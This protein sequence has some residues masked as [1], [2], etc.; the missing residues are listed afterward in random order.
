LIGFDARTD[1]AHIEAVRRGSARPA[2][3]RQISWLAP[4]FLFSEQF[5]ERTK[6]AIRRF[7]DDLPFEL[8][9]QRGNSDLVVHLTEQ[10]AEWGELAEQE[11]YQARPHEGD[12]STVE[13]VHVSPSAAK[14]ENVVKAEKATTSLQEGNLWV[15]ASKIF[16]HEKIEDEASVKT[17]LA[18]ARKLDT[19]NL[20]AASDDEDNLGMR[21]GA[22]AG[23]AAVVLRFR[24]GRS[25]DELAWARDAVQ[26]ATIAPEVRGNFWMPESAIP[27][28]HS[29]YAARGLA[30]DIRCGTA[31]P[32]APGILLALAAHPLE[33]VSLAAVKAALSLWDIDA[34][35][36]WAALSIALTLCHVE[37]DGKRHHHNDP[38]HSETQIRKLLRSVLKDYERGKKWMDLPSPPPAWVKVE[39][40]REKRREPTYV[41]DDDDYYDSSTDG[42]TQ[43]R[44]FWRSKYA[45]KVIDNVPFEIALASPPASALLD[46]IDRSL[47]WT[48]DKIEPPW[49]KGSHRR[50]RRA[51]EH[52]EW[53]HGFG[54]V[55]GRLAGILPVDRA[56][57]L[58]VEPIL[59]LDG[60]P[61]WSLLSPFTSALVCRYVYDAANVPNG[62]IEI[63]SICLDKLLA[64]PELKKRSDRGGELHGFDLPSLAQTL[65]FVSVEKADLAAR[66]VNGDWSQIEMILPLV[67]R[68]VR[69]AG[70]SGTVMG[71]F[72]TLCERSRSH[73]PSEAFADQVLSILQSRDASELRGWHGTFLPARIASLV[74]HFAVRDTPMPVALG[75][76]LLR[77]LDVLVDMG[78]RRSAA[79]QLSESFREVRLA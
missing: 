61:C 27:W 26:R 65:M 51:T 64:A 46:F 63:L 20:F 37:S 42:W 39:P 66:F 58:V 70:W 62:T 13:I 23:A 5:A 78:D 76:K 25:A 31:D 32:A 4:L 18:L 71:H 7:K 40:P 44:T 50:E 77:T 33:C 60:E 72:L 38:Y 48:I 29:M 19:P 34:R 53:I 55:A 15:W 16:E 14:P 3:R 22:V 8:E 56:K 9:E 67:D 36:A 12:D 6:S 11:N 69:A 52:F 28:H 47:K 73:Y 21:R 54:G 2:R 49:A 57:S 1:K 75:Q 79:L 24:E 17:A 35:L 59:A 30:A 10:A 41:H 43:P 45:G 74:Q 68:Y